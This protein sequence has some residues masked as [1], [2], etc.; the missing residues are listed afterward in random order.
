MHFHV[1]HEL[2]SSKDKVTSCH[3]TSTN[4]LYTLNI[5]LSQQGYWAS[6]QVCSYFLQVNAVCKACQGHQHWIYYYV[7]LLLPRSLDLAGIDLMKHVG[8]PHAPGIWQHWSR[9]REPNLKKLLFRYRK[10][11]DFSLRKQKDQVTVGVDLS[12]KAMSSN[13]YRGSFTSTSFTKTHKALLHVRMC[14]FAD[15]A[16]APCSIL[17]TI[18]HQWLLPHGENS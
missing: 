11:K 16:A 17:C 2:F 6:L 10:Q 9:N 12:I 8:L 18:W 13:S 1:T 5:L 4:H 3:L 14:C 15:P 7:W